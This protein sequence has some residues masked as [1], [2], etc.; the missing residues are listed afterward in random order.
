MTER[1]RTESTS[2]VPSAPYLPTTA[3]ASRHLAPD[4]ATR[5]LQGNGVGTASSAGAAGIS[6]GAVN[7][8]DIFSDARECPIDEPL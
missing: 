6:N 1:T 3:S 2:T 7:Y 4:G 5:G 8:N